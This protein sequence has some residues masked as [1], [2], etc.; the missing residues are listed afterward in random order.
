MFHTN[1]ADISSLNICQCLEPQVLRFCSLNEVYY[2]SGWVMR[3][4]FDLD[5]TDPIHAALCKLACSDTN[6][7]ICDAAQGEGSEVSPPT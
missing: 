4:Y 2:C 1:D 6:L 7:D 3:L 5:K